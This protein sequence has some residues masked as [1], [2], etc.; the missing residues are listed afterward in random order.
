MASDYARKSEKLERESGQVLNY[1]QSV[2]YLRKRWPR[3]ETRSEILAKFKQIKMARGPHWLAE[4]ELQ[5]G[6]DLALTG[7]PS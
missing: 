1:E 4:P 7:G 5:E 6:S 3:L 2:R